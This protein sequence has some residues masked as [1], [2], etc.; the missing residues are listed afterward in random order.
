MKMQIRNLINNQERQENNTSIIENIIKKVF[1]FFLKI[2][3]NN[4]MYLNKLKF[5]KYLT[6]F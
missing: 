6:F 1:D 4:V 3:S 2:S 5:L